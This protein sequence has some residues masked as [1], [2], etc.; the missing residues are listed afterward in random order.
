LIRALPAFHLLLV[1][2]AVGPARAQEGPLSLPAAARG[3]E[4]EVRLRPGALLLGEDAEARVEIR[5]PTDEGVKSVTVLAQHGGIS[6]VQVTDAARGIATARYE[7]PEAFLPRVDVVAAFARTDDGLIWGYSAVQLVGQGQ[8]VIRTAPLADAIIR[9][10]GRTYGPV[11]SS[12]KGTATIQIRVPPGTVSGTDGEGG[13]VSLGVPATERTAIFCEKK[14]LA[15]DEHGAEVLAVVFGA[16]GAID[17]ET[18]PVLGADRGEVGAPRRVGPGMFVAR[19]SPAQ[20][21]Q[22]EVLLEASVPGEERPSAKSRIELTSG[23]GPGEVARAPEPPDGDAPVAPPPWMDAALKVGFVWNPGVLRTFDVAVDL[24]VRMPDPA[25]GLSLGAE[26]AF[27]RSSQDGSAPVALGSARVASVMWLVPISGVITYRFRLGRRWALPIHAQAGAM[28]VDN[29]LTT[30]PPDL[31]AIT[32]HER[33]YLFAVGGGLAAELLL[34]K[35]AVILE[36]KYLG[37][38]GSLET[39]DG[40]LSTF[41]LNAGYRLFFL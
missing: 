14:E 6:E 29:E 37:A 30:E 35:G 8:A 21:G 3:G 27:S 19:W 12:R 18:V 2:L 7:P 13:E 38:V 39:V 10:G 34:G 33:G 31:P 24:G 1:V 28:L 23:E 20:P 5:V 40:S 11:K 41:R 15:A 9:I 32:D 36:L 26:L 25:G 4:V 16:D 17:D 22:G